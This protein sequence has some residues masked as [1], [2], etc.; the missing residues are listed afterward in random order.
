MAFSKFLV[1]FI[2]YDI[3]VSTRKE[4]HYGFNGEKQML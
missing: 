2:Q 4:V 1:L 3:I